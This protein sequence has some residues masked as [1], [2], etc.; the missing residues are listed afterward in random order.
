MNQWKY[1][2]EVESFGLTADLMYKLDRARGLFGGPIVITSGYR[3]PLKNKE[4]G[5]VHDSAHEK[6]MAVDIRC[7]DIEMQKRLIWALCVAGFHRIGAYDKH[8]HA[9]TDGS[10]PSPAFWCG[11][12]H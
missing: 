12:S 2:D 9:D 11:E 7:A 6:G 3:D 8:V 4:V 10:K 5:G 1:F